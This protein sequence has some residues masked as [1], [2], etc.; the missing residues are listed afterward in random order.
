MGAAPD[1]NSV[2]I[3]TFLHGGF[4]EREEYSYVRVPGT[5]KGERV[6]CFGFRTQTT[7]RV[8][9]NL[10]CI[11]HARAFVDASTLKKRRQSV[12]GQREALWDMEASDDKCEEK[13]IQ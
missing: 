4:P 6:S 5:F 7:G 1:G 3:E 13:C 2:R 11:Q 10:H 9:F 8:T 12:L